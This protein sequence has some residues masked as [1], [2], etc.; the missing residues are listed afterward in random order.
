MT[1]SRYKTQAVTAPVWAGMYNR[2]ATEFATSV[3]PVLREFYETTPLG[4]SNRQLLDVCCGTGQLAR[5]FLDNGYSV[6]GIDLSAP[7]LEYAR[8]NTEEYVADGRARYLVADASDF[9]LDPVFGLATCTYNTLNL[10]ENESALADCF[11]CVFDS[12]AD[13]GTFVFDLITRRGFWH[14]YN[15]TVVVD[16]EEELLVIKSV[17]DGGD[18]ASNSQSGF[19]VTEDGEWERFQEYR[20]PRLF[21]VDVVLAHL[22]EAGWSRTWVASVRDP[23]SPVDDPEA[24]TRVFYVA[25]E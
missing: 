21:D 11:R 14:D 8:R 7:M 2:A 22:K 9:S 23:A 24:L 12:L 3:A 25:T 10:L 6:T 1:A 19:A 18:T 16:T 15:A 20:Y 17:Y 13:G 5:H 4:A